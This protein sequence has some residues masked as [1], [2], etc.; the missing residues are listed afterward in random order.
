LKT[1]PFSERRLFQARALPDVQKVCPVMLASVLWRNPDSGYH[2]DIT[3]FGVQRDRNPFFQD[4]IS[5]KEQIF[6]LPDGVLYD[7]ESAAYCGNVKQ[8]LKKQGVLNSEINRKRI[9]VMGTFTMGRTLNNSGAA[10]AGF[11]TFC[12]LTN[13][14]SDQINFGTIELEKGSDPIKAA[15]QLNKILPED[16]EVIS[17]T[18]FMNREIN[19]WEAA[20]PVGYIITGGMIIAMLVGAIILY[21]I[22]YTDINDHLKEYATLKAL[23]LNN[24]FFISLILQESLILLGLSFLPSLSVC[25]VL[26]RFTWWYAGIPAGL[27]LTDTFTALILSGIMCASAG[28]FA[29]RCLRHADP[30][31]IF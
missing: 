7:S 15:A 19:F 3:L 28:Y 9:R 21:Q 6:S 13:R 10:L 2:Y 24:L 17:K 12:R 8:N 5:Q 1:V 16:V 4:E 18:E 11:E 29:T 22:L 26:F 14:A 20:T 30:A 27:S 31:D 23:G 25:Y